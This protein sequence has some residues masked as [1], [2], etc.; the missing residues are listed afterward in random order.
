MRKGWCNDARRQRASDPGGVTTAPKATIVPEITEMLG[1]VLVKKP[2]HAHV[3]I[4]EVDHE[5]RGFAGVPTSKRR[6]AAK[7]PGSDAGS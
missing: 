4:D 5:N 6:G 3:V 1:R 7:P 2:E